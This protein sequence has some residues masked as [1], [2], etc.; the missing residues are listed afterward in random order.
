V[1][2]ETDEEHRVCLEALDFM[3]EFARSEQE[4]R[5]IEILSKA[6]E[7]YELAHHPIADP[8]PEQAAAFRLAEG[9]PICAQKG[10]VPVGDVSGKTCSRCGMVL[11]IIR[12]HAVAVALREAICK[13]KGHTP[14]LSFGGMICCA[15]CGETLKP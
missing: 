15:R 3:M 11:T 8:T 7:A 2:I 4:S 10:H 14:T 12:P 1:I 6:I 13:G 9:G 5:G